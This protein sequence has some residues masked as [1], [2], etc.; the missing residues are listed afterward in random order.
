MT[1]LLIIH[2]VIYITLIYLNKQ[3]GDSLTIIST[4]KILIYLFMYV[5]AIARV[6]K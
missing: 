6:L 5:L 3:E 1:G 4:D 2:A